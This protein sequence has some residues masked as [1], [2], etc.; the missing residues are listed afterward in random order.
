MKRRKTFME[1]RIVALILLLV[2]FA[3]AQKPKASS[4]STDKTVHVRQYTRKDGTVV[5]AYDRRAPG[6][7][8]KTVPASRS[9]AANSKQT[10]SVG[11]ASP[12]KGTS[13][14]D[15]SSLAKST[16]SSK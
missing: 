9:S 2:S 13:S 4:S 5:Q 14:K 1:M 7:A 11:K 3:V 10:L 16:K 8:T 15:G 6:T 12:T